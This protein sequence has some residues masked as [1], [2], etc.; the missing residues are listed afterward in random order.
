VSLIDRDKTTLSKTEHAKR[1]ALNDLLDNNITLE[2]YRTI[3][4]RQKGIGVLKIKSTPEGARIFIDG[5]YVKITPCLPFT[6]P[7]GKY[8]LKIV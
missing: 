4:R 8:R 3:L 6:Q 5:N 2:N 7:K 1:R